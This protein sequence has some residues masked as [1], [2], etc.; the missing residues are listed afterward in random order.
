MVKLPL[1]RNWGRSGFSLGGVGYTEWGEAPEH[2]RYYRI[3][4]SV[5]GE[6]FFFFFKDL[7]FIIC[8]YTVA[9]LRHSRR[10]SQISSW[11]VV[12]HHVV[13]RTWT[14]D[15]RKSS[16][17]LLPTEPSHQPPMENLYGHVRLLC[18][19]SGLGSSHKP[20]F[21]CVVSLDAMFPISLRLLSIW[22]PV[23]AVM[24]D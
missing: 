17:V 18:S 15:L 14:Q 3:S 2:G 22:P 8:K 21:C 11:M 13:A 20:D 12:S 24:K 4:T 5:D 6:P 9:V 16:W 23:G 1:G 10:G 7:L 19:D